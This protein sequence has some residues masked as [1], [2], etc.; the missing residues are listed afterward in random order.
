MSKLPNH[1]RSD[2]QAKYSR[3]H[4]DYTPMSK[5]PNHSRSDY[6][7]KYSRE[8]IDYATNVFYNPS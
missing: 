5:L 7:A 8:H 4:I 2:Y 1:S 6:Q 3:D